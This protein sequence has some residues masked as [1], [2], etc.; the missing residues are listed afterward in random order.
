MVHGVRQG[1]GESAG[2]SGMM[3]MMMMMMMGIAICLGTMMMSFEHL[4][5]KRLQM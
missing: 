2:N 3:M 5:K 1:S 4:E